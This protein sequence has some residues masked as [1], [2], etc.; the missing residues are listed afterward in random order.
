M[1]LH[2]VNDITEKEIEDGF[3]Y[4]GAFMEDINCE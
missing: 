2:K 1:K 3:K 4:L